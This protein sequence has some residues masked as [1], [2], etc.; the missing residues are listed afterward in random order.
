MVVH[1]SFTDAF[2]PYGHSPGEPDVGR[3]NLPSSE[4]PRERVLRTRQPPTV[5]SPGI[6]Q[7]V[8]TPQSTIS[9]VEV[10]NPLVEVGRD[11]VSQGGGPLS[12]MGKALRGKDFFVFVC[13]CV[14]SP[15]PV[16]VPAY[17]TL[18]D[19]TLVPKSPR[20]GGCVDS[21]GVCILGGLGVQSHP[22]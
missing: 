8:D 1:D 6:R 22:F 2:L 3:S 21:P 7:T 17:R 13:V 18:R 4:T 20:D 11:G 10:V 14:L 16:V 12:R 9:D 5:P 15:V 19:P